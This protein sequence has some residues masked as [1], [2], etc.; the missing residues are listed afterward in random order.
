MQASVQRTTREHPENGVALH[1]NKIKK[2]TNLNEPDDDQ[3]GNKC[4]FDGN[5]RLP[6]GRLLVGI[7]GLCGDT[8]LH[9]LRGVSEQSVETEGTGDD[10]EDEVGGQHRPEDGD[11][12]AAPHDGR[13]QTG[14]VTVGSVTLSDQKRS[15]ATHPK[16]EMRARRVYMMTSTTRVGFP[17]SVRDHLSSVGRK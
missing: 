13:H 7:L 17:V 9:V 8:F 4:A 14:C 1:G 10:G 5:L 6:A 16:T 3:D 11:E 12:S 15:K 2:R